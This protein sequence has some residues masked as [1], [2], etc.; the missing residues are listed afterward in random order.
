VVAFTGHT[1]GG[2]CAFA[3]E[4]TGVRIFCDESLKRFE[5][6]FPACGS[7]S[8][9]VEMT[10]DELFQFSKAEAWL[11]VCKLPEIEA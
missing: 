4:H 10:C 11:D 1:I 7:A 8:S 9:T 2:V 3:I 5:T 6:V